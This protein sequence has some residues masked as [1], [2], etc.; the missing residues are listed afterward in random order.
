MIM[1]LQR[2]KS[3]PHSLKQSNLITRHF[4]FVS[5]FCRTI[6]RFVFCILLSF[7]STYLIQRE[8]HGQSKIFPID[9][10]INSQVFS[11]CNFCPPRLPITEKHKRKPLITPPLAK[12]SQDSSSF[13]SRNYLPISFLVAWHY[14]LS[15][16]FKI[17][18]RNKKSKCF[19]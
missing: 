4:Y 5:I 9:I 16:I 6:S 8:Q 12:I 19:S 1:L 17:H 3:W 14:K 11:A 2:M 7:F 15:T 13:S 10:S 18:D